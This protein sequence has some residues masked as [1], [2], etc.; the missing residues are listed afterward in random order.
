MIMHE[1][2]I[3][4]VSNTFYLFDDTL[5]NNVDKL[6]R[7]SIIWLIELLTDGSITKSMNRSINHDIILPQIH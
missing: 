2:T 1:A 3:I 5:H 6:T 7:Q 4:K